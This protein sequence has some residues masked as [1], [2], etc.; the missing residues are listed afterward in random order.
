MPMPG[1]RSSAAVRIDLSA[2][3]AIG[4]VENLRQIQINA[5]Q[6]RGTQIV[7]PQLHVLV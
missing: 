1:V 5:N 4:E 7:L 6:V 2:M 3:S